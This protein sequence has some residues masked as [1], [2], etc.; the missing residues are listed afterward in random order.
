MHK[1]LAA[2]DLIKERSLQGQWL[3]ADQLHDQFPWG[4]QLVSDW[5]LTSPRQNLVKTLSKAIFVKYSVL[6]PRA[7]TF[8]KKL[9][10]KKQTQPKCTSQCTKQKR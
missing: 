3:V 5:S 10:E 6:R 4:H 8:W 7:G 9:S 1:N 2:T